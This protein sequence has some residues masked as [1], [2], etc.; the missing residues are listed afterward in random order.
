MPPSHQAYVTWTPQ[1]LYHWASKTGPYTEA[2]VKQL[3]ESREHPQQGFRA[4]LGILRLG[5]RYGDTRLEKA[6]ERALVLGVLRYRSIESILKNSLDTKP[7]ISTPVQTQADVPSH[8]NVRGSDYY[9][10]H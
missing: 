4:A 9:T 3:I 10:S 2:F 6:C 7:L 5:K 8:L 1:R